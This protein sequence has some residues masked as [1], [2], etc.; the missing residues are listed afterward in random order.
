MWRRK[1]KPLRRRIHA[2]A[3]LILIEL[4]KAFLSRNFVEV[5]RKFIEFF[6]AL[7]NFQINALFSLLFSLPLEKLLS[8]PL[9]IHK[10]TAQIEEK[11]ERKNFYRK[12]FVLCHDVLA[13]N[14]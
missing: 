2:L 5:G 11:T 1:K 3:F 9:K 6:K 12:H 4:L 10:F 14:E 13:L 7:I 8:S